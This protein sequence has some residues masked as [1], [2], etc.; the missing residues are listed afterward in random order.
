MS[1]P[2]VRDVSMTNILRFAPRAAL[3]AG[4]TAAMR[5]AG[6]IA[7]ILT[8]FAHHRRRA[9]D[10][11]WLKENAEI[12]GILS[13]LN[14]KLPDLALAAYQPFHDGAADQIARYPQYYRMILGLVTALEDLGYP[15]DL[16]PRLADWVLAE[17]WPDSEVNDLQR[18]EVRYLLARNGVVWAPEGLDARLMGFACRSDTFALPNP[19][20]AYDLLH[21]VFYLADYG[22]RPLVLPQAALDSLLVLGCLAHLEQNGDLLAEV[23]LA[24][25]FA[26]QPLPP[27]WLGHVLQEASAFRVEAQPCA[28]SSDAYHNYLVNQ[29]LLGSIGETAF[30]VNS[31]AGPM[32]F[33][34]PRPVISPLRE[35]G[36]ALVHPGLERSRDWGALRAACAPHLSPQALAQADAGAEGGPMFHRF[37]AAFARVGGPAE[38]GRRVTA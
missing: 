33:H 13:A 38:G 8:A 28:D 17:G 21:V 6:G 16:G 37:I 34:L 36:Q 25:R 20:A 24:L 15:G 9:G 26:G 18:A 23:C 3:A 5:P 30:G 7:Q 1:G 10:A 27:L 4:P 35:W 14:R 32:R 29:W 22:R 19:R 12:L 11:F 31:G 2:P